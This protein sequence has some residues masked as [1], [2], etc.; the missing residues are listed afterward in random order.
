M[1][2]EKS[3]LEAYRSRWQAVADVENEE[4][5]H[6]PFIERWKK[7]NSIIRL[8]LTLGLEEQA[9]EQQIDVVRRRWNEL[10]DRHVRGMKSQRP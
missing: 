3:M 2:L 8:A 9:D 5:R 4:Q 7:L 10:K 6:M 1:Q